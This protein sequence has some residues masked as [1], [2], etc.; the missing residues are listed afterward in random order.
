LFAAACCGC[1]PAAAAASTV[2]FSLW[3]AAAAIQTA[4]TVSACSQLQQ[5]SVSSVN[6]SSFLIIM[7]VVVVHRDLFSK[8]WTSSFLEAF[9]PSKLKAWCVCEQWLY[10]SH[11]EAKL[12][13]YYAKP[14][15]Y[16]HML[17]WSIRE[18]S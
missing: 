16:I 12:F 2:F 13:E 18:V 6:W 3:I 10:G 17:R 1:N 9:P 4:A 14:R 8:E 7:E 11:F 5:Y 15:S